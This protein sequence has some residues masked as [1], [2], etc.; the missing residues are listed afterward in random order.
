MPPKYQ[1]SQFDDRGY[2]WRV[3]TTCRMLA[4]ESVTVFVEKNGQKCELSSIL[5]A[6]QRRDISWLT[7]WG[8]IL[9]L[10]HEKGI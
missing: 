6:P 2:S 1:N 8:H 4:F 10:I 9:C 7:I 5:D 3:A